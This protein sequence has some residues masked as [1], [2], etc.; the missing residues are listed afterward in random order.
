VDTAVEHQENRVVLTPGGSR[1]RIARRLNTAYASGLLSEETFSHRIDDLLGSR[2][3]DPRVLV[4]DLNLRRAS[5]SWSR[6]SAGV[7]RGLAHFR[8]TRD[9][10]VPEPVLLALDWSGAQT[11]LLVGRSGGCDVVLT[12]PTVSRCHAR[13]L[14]RDGSWIVNDLSSTNGTLVNGVQVGRSELRPGDDLLLGDERLR[15]D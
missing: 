6:L 5:R 14:F 9:L 3:V 13:L 12:D 7:Q 15:I 8:P 1:T 11:E 2:L 10:P 4:G